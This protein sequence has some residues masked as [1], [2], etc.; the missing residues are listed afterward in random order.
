MQGN[1]MKDAHKVIAQALLLLLSL[2]GVGIALYLTS[3]HYEHVPLL[4]SAQ[5]FVDCQRVTSSAYSVVPGT[6]LPIT[7]PGLGWA[8]VSAVLAIVGLRTRS[9]YRRVVL[10]Q[11]IWS[12]LALI[13]V[14]YL[15]YVELVLLHTICAWCTGLHVIILITFLIA[16][17]QLLVPS[18]DEDEQEDEETPSFTSASK[19]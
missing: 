2:V 10:A 7:V 6:S 1:L 16:I 12:L 19:S 5:G 4:C 11:C 8:V 9:N 13:T 17:Q 15:V 18:Q 14:L 3:V